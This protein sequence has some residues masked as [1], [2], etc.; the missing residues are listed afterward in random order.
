MHENLWGTA[1]MAIGVIGALLP[2]T[3]G[4]RCP[5][6]LAIAHMAMA[7]V[8]AGM[9][10][11]G[12]AGNWVT[13]VGGCFLFGVSVWVTSDGADPSTVRLCATDLTAMSVIMV[14]V[15][16]AA[17]AVH[18]LPSEALPQL[19]GHHHSLGGGITPG[20]WLGAAVLVVWAAVAIAVLLSRQRPRPEKMRNIVAT[21][22]MITAMA[23]M[24]A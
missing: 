20:A 11:P 7:V 12:E 23:P 22:L 9:L 8:M 19:G 17:S 10:F 3:S 6:R 15:S 14:F 5:G 21:A 24:A 18:D 16:P 13:L 1:L 4:G 2:L